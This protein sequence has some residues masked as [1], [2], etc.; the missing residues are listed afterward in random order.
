MCLDPK[1][2]FDYRRNYP[3]WIGFFAE[4]ATHHS[5]LVAIY[6]VCMDHLDPFVSSA[7]R[8]KSILKTETNTAEHDGNYKNTHMAATR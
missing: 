5:M 1:R 7:Q 6:F 4:Y 8:R 3:W 2:F